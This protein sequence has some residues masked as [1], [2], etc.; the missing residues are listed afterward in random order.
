[1]GN[2][3]IEYQELPRGNGWVLQV[4]KEDMTWMNVDNSLN[5][6]P[7]ECFGKLSGSAG[8]DKI[9]RFYIAVS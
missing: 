1:M 3:R 9:L 7:V 8:Y 4:Q 2:F 6:N 5:K